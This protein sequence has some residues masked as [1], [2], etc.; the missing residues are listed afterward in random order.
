MMFPAV[1]DLKI[2]GFVDMFRYIFSRL[3]RI[4]FH[5]NAIIFP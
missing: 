1:S 3:Q 4:K 2:F 5:Q